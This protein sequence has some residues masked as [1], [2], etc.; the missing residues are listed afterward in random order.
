[1]SGDDIQN[2]YEDVD[3]FYS[4]THLSTGK[5]TYLAVSSGSWTTTMN[6]RNFHI[7]QDNTT[8]T[9][10]SLEDEAYNHY[11]IANIDWYQV[12]APIDRVL[13]LTETPDRTFV[14]DFD[15]PSGLQNKMSLDDVQAML[16]YFVIE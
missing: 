12:S 10:G 5:W 9:T 11:N 1:M 15:D 8:S 7:T 6:Q 3:A 4:I 14:L 16:E 2:I 13:L